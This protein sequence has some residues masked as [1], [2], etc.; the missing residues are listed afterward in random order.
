M[1][2]GSVPCP[3]SHVR[4]AVLA[5]TAWRCGN[6]SWAE[7]TREPQRRTM[8][9]SGIFS[10]LSTLCR[11]DHNLPQAKLPKTQRFQT[12]SS[13]AGI[14]THQGYVLRTSCSHYCTFK[15]ETIE[16]I[17]THTGNRGPFL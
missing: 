8:G 11:Q 6:L 7:G 17:S 2:L 15:N 3:K 13:S 5:A 9:Q 14:M 4:H 12:L 1:I 10:P 16:N